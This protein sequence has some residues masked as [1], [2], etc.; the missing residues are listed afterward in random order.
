MEGVNA[1]NTP[2]SCISSK[3]GGW[4]VLTE[5]T[6]VFRVREGVEGVYQQRT[7]LSHNL[8]EGGAGGDALTKETPPLSCVSSEGGGGSS[9]TMKRTLSS[10][11]WFCCV[12][13]KLN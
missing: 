7:P 11:C 13:S 6:L 5:E 10:S 4:R 8:S 1:G 9:N 12:V 3:R 2:L